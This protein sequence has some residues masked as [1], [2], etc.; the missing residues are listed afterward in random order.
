[1]FCGVFAT[2]PAMNPRTAIPVSGG[3]AGPLAPT[4]PG[5]SWHVMHAYCC[6]SSL[7]RSTLPFP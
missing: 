6:I 4:T 1:M 3:P 5:I 2:T 7:P